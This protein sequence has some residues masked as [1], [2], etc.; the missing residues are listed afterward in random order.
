MGRFDRYVLGVFLRYW[1][2]VGGAILGTFLVLHLLGNSDELSQFE[3]SR[4]ALALD[5]LRWIALNLPYRWLEFAPYLTL[6]AGLATV[7][8]LA[9]RREWTPVLAAGRSAPRAVLPLLLAALAIGALSALVRE[10]LQPRL[11]EPR[12]ALEWKLDDQRPWVLEDVSLRSRDDHRLIARVFRP[13]PARVE[14]L[15]VYSRG[16]RGED[17]LLLADTAAWDGAAW[18]LEGGRRIVPGE[19]SGAAAS[20]AHAELGPADL[21]RAAIAASSPLDLSSAQLQEVLARDP[22]HRQAATL[23]WAWRAA[24]FGHLVLL[25]L[26]IPF[27]LRFDRRSSLEGLGYG[28]LLS[29]LYFVAEIVLRDLGG[30]GALPPPVAGAGALLIF[31]ALAAIQ[32]RSPGTRRSAG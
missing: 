15:E 27:V 22:H 18:Q 31:A 1:V 5:I 9:R 25:L 21:L 3:G 20:F 30:R 23:L 26:G 7:L 4:G 12:L 6:I 16:P 2:V 17:V 28:M 11:A 13:H 32:W 19:A 29:L 10:E 14:G 24:P 8:H